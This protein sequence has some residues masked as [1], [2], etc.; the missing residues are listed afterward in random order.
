M[1]GGKEG[2]ISLSDCFFL[3]C[4]A[5]ANRNSVRRKK[6]FTAVIVD[7]ESALEVDFG[8]VDVNYQ[9][10]FAQ[11]AQLK[12]SHLE[13]K[14][15][16][17]FGGWTMPEPFHAMAKDPENVKWFAKTAVELIA[18][19]D[20]FDGIDLDWEY[21]VGGGLTTSPWNPETKL[22]DEDK[23]TEKQAI[24]RLVKE[25]RQNMDALGSK[26]N[27]QVYLCGSCRGITMGS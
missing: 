11:F 16:P 7:Q 22:S 26:T 18:K 3:R 27:M 6:P 5:A 15:L 10:H 1:V 14:I 17:L 23:L 9:G 19:Y 20:F 13:L 12:K 25:L 24:T 8:E 21:P 2:G 4:D